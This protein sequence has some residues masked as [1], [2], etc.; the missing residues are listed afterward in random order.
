MSTQAFRL[1]GS[2]R[3]YGAEYAQWWLV[4]RSL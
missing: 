1:N 4:Q 3:F 2:E